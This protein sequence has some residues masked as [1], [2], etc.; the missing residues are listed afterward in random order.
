[1]PSSEAAAIIAGASA[2]GGGAIVAASNYALGLLQAREARQTELR[3]ALIELGYVVSRIDHL[4]RTEPRSGRTT[5]FVNKQMARLP[6]VDYTIERTRRRLL[7]PHL[8]AL[9]VELARA[10]TAASLLAPL[11]LLPSMEALTEAMSS[12]DQHDEAWQQRWNKARTG[13]FVECRKLLGSGVV[14]RSDGTS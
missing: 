8:D 9:V 10:L 14:E 7:E 12:A 2:V 5:R 3:R 13:Y 1:M 11:K 6:Q 4:L